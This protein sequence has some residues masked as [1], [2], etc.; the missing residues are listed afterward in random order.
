MEDP[1]HERQKPP[2]HGQDEDEARSY[3]GESH[4]DEYDDEMDKYVDFDRPEQSEEHEELGMTINNLKCRCAMLASTN[5]Y[6]M[7]LQWLLDNWDSSS[8]KEDK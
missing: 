4:E 7:D 2:W 6:M 5:E 1:H 8:H 3:H